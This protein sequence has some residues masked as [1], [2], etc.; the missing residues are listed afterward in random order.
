M[1]KYKYIIILALNIAFVVSCSDKD[2]DMSPGNPVIEAKTQF[3]KAY[4][5]DNLSFTIGVSDPVPLSTL[6]AKLYFGDEEVAKTVIRTKTDGDYSG[7]IPV[8]FFKDI[9]DGTATL[10]FTLMDTHLTSVTKSFDV[11]VSRPQFPYLIL[12]TET[13]SYPMVS[14]GT[15]Y[16]YAATEAFPST[17]LPA[18]IKTPVADGN[19][20][21]I[22][23]G[24]E[25]GTV[26]QGVVDNI[27]YI[28]QQAGT[29]SVTF[30]TKTY[31][32]GPFFEIFVNEQKMTMVDKENFRI[33]LDLKQ[34]QELTVD[35]IG[36]IAEWWIDTD[37]FTKV[38]DNQ[39]TFA[40]MDGKYR[41]IANT[42]LKYFKVETMSGSSLATLQA[43]GSGAIWVI[44]NNVG[45]PSVAANQ[46]GWNPSLAICMAPIG[47]KKYRLTLVGGQTVDTDV[48][49]FKFFHQKD[50][51]GEFASSTLSTGSDLIF[52]G[53][54]TNG[55]DNGNLGIVADKTLDEGATYEFVVDVSA[56]ITKAV[57][58]VTKK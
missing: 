29:F 5:G 7:T 32:T 43:D 13:A 49:D 34:G 39:F 8:P 26:M 24:W 33:D 57:L 54:G 6:T 51:G 12:V 11:P 50:W 4:F 30:N 27:P 22:T 23:F 40:P 41:I 35:G 15:P 56:G 3:T 58:T 46:T 37:W 25:G 44:G 45:K 19:G 2:N 9:P 47:D 1:K 53:D 18:Y 55:R 17:D 20:N 48:I 38:A 42:S 10:E 16:E 52:V 36:N 31:E 21:E 28:S 14:T